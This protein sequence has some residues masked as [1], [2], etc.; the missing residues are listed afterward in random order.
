MTTIRT[1]FTRLSVIL[2]TLLELALERW[3]IPST[4]AEELCNLTTTLTLPD[5]EPGSI[6]FEQVEDHGDDAGTVPDPHSF[7]DE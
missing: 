2:G 4:P 3:A 7:D 6:R 5:D 1:I